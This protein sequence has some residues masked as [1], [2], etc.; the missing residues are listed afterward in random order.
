MENIPDGTFRSTVQGLL[1]KIQYSSNPLREASQLFEEL[2]QSKKDP[3]ISKSSALLRKY[4]KWLPNTPEK[5]A[6]Y[7]AIVYT[8]IQLL[9]RSPNSKIEYNDYFINEYNQTVLQINEE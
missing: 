4:E 8:L 9:G 6:A 3:T 7:I 1:T 5:I 2:Q